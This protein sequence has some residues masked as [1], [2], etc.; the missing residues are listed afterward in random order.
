MPGTRD[1]LLPKSKVGYG[2]ELVF[3]DTLVCSKDTIVL[4]MREQFFNHLLPSRPQSQTYSL[5]ASVT[6]PSIIV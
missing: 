6:P 2:S 4:L 5:T 1:E 3:W